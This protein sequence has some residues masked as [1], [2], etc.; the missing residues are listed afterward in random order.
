MVDWSQ[1]IAA[2]LRDDTRKFTSFFLLIFPDWTPEDF[3]KVCSRIQQAFGDVGLDFNGQIP[4]IAVKNER[5]T[6]GLDDRQRCA[7]ESLLFGR[8][9]Q[10]GL[11]LLPH[12]KDPS[13]ARPPGFQDSMLVPGPHSIG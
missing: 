13:K 11:L 7:A 9:N 8:Y 5:V 12:Q 3:E 2:Y 1:D 6:S 4:R 10:D